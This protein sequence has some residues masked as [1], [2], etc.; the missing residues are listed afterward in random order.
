MQRVGM[1][2]Y[3]DFQV[4]CFA[5]FSVFEVA[6]REAGK[7]LYDLE[8][9]GNGGRSVRGSF[10]QEVT[11]A[12]LVDTGF[13]TLLV[14][15]GIDIPE[16]DPAVS[17]FLVDTSARTRR[18]AS[19]CLGS[20][21]LGDAGLLDGKK[22][23]THWNFGDRMRARYPKCTVDLDRIYVQSGRI[24]SSA[25][26]SAGIDLALGL[27]EE[28][29]GRELTAMIAKGMVLHHR[30]APGQSQHSTL[31]DIDAR[32]D[33]IQASL[34]YARRN[35]RNELSVA[36][37]ATVAHLS[38]RH[39]ARAFRAETGQ[40]PAQ[41]VA[42]LRMEQARMLITQGT[43]AMETIA[44]DTGFGD[45]ERMRRA[46]VRWQGTAPTELRRRSRADQDTTAD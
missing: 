22:A 28:D 44:R 19:I 12:P 17:D 10:G 36:E 25:G 20:F 46:F 16:H 18:I 29:H 32:S 9:L 43:L 38:P 8:V 31:L 33:R 37:L 4:L 39:F 2:V 3:P 24:W 45:T 13:D 21:V 41:A 5:A 40:T 14:G 35:L 23:T 34:A 42:A 26:M 11:C 30:R 15:V 27:V 6:N 1:I 7:R